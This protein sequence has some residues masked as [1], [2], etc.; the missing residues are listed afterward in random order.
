MNQK[1]SIIVGSLIVAVGL[2]ALGLCMRSGLKSIAQSDRT[3]DVR[4]LAEREVDA[5]YVTWPI[6]FKE[7]GNDLPAVYEKV[8]KTNK[9]IV[10][11]LTENGIPENEI[12]IGA[13]EVRDLQA[14]RYNDYPV[15]FNYAIT[16]IVTVS[17]PKVKEVHG[18]IIR[19]GELFAKGIAITNDYSNQIK[20]E[21]TD[22]NSIKPQMIEEATKNARE[23]ALKF[24]NDSESRLGKIKTAYQGQF[25][26][27]DI[28]E[29]TPYIKRVRVVTSLT[30]YLED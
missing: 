12:Y 19:Q 3:V 4:G 17:S 6:M 1:V 11:F 27:L 9:T 2:L 24:A 15:P 14:D 13:P 5:N 29:T 28:N 30:Y 16:S 8:A 26:I 7:V 22:L 23:A 18:L 21:F 10:D 25:S 20:Y